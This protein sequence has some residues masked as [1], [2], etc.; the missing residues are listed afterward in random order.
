LFKDD[1]NIQPTSIGVNE[2][3]FNTF[4]NYQTIILNEVENLSSG[5]INEALQYAN[6]GGTLLF[7]PS[8][9]GNLDS[10]KMLFKGLKNIQLGEY[11]EQNGY[12]TGVDVKNELFKSVFS[13]DLTDVRFPQYKGFYA[14]ELQQKLN[15]KILFKS[16]SNNPLFMQLPLGKGQ[17][18]I[19]AFSLNSKVTDFGIH[20]LFVPLFY[21]LVLYSSS[22]NELFYWLKPG[23]FS[24]ISQRNSEVGPLSMIEL[25]S[26]KEIKPKYSQSNT[27]LVIFPEI[28]ILSAGHYSVI[29]DGNFQN[30]LSYNFDRTESDISYYTMDEV[31]K[32]FEGFGETK[33]E[34]I[35]ANSKNLAKVIHQQTQGQP[36]TILFL[37]LAI[38]A[39][40]AEMALLRFLK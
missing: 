18:Y 19:S 20:P 6:Q 13:S 28:N 25:A 34:I 8:L 11:I 21:N 38:I 2:I 1:E 10:Y 40:L 27:D 17:C 14:I 30:Y 15:S 31:N 37:W 3:P 4:N 22:P 35:D 36:L 16:E 7:I 32:L 12:I 5:L 39:L 26:K 23:M 24:K 33:I 29:R 9:N